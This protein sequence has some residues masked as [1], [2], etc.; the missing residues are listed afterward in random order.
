MKNF[1][2]RQPTSTVKVQSIP[3]LSRMTLLLIHL[4]YLLFIASILLWG[5]TVWSQESESKGNEN[6]EVEEESAQTNI[7]FD[8][9]LIEDVDLRRLEF[10]AITARGQ[11]LKKKHLYRKMMTFDREMNESFREFRYQQ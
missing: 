6:F 5:Q 4:S 8:A 9:G 7:E 10:G 2:R 1:I 11:G 3:Q